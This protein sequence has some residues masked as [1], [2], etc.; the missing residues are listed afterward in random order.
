MSRCPECGRTDCF[1][2]WSEAVPAFGPRPADGSSV[3]KNYRAYGADGL[4][5]TAG[6]PQGSAEGGREVSS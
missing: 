1:G 5:L 6:Q 3:F 2:H 4:P